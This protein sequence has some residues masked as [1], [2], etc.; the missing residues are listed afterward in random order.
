VTE[1]SIR[2]ER[3]IR[4]I[5]EHTSVTSHASDLITDYRRLTIRI[6]VRAPSVLMNLVILWGVADVFRRARSISS[7]QPLGA[8]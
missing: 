1:Q 7:A 8:R 5:A 6:A 3:G 2:P 4:T